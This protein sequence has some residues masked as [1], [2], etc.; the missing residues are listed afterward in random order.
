MYN[1]ANTSIK[2]RLLQNFDYSNFTISNI[3]KFYVVMNYKLEM[4]KIC[5]S[6]N[7]AH[8]SF[9]E[10]RRFNMTLLVFQIYS[11]HEIFKKSYF[12]IRVKKNK[13]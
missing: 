2:G 13:K 8:S 12:T 11:F 9:L 5:K 6:Y 1:N 3:G 7:I 4:S 10:E